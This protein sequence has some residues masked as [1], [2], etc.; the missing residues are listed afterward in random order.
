M[1]DTWTCKCGATHPKTGDGN[2]GGCVCI[3]AY[4]G[5]SI[6]TQEHCWCIGD[7]TDVPD[8][9][10]SNYV[11]LFGVEGCT[12]CVGG[13]IKAVQDLLQVVVS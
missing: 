6:T 4:A 10:G 7:G 13:V 5:A 11:N 2:G 12:T 8:T 1:T 3:G 9:A